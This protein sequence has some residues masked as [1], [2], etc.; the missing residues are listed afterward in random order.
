MFSD[1]MF[2]PNFVCWKIFGLWP[3]RGK[4]K[5]YKYYSFIYLTT[6][7]V[8]YNMLLTLNLV[9][10]P[11]AVETLIR[12]VIFYFNEIVVMC[13]VTMVLSMRK[14]IMAAFALLDSETF[15]CADNTSWKTSEKLFS[16]YRKLWKFYAL[17]SH[18][19]YVALVLPP[20]ANFVLN[21]QLSLPVCNY[22]FLSEETRR[23]YY[24]FWLTY[25][26]IGIY[27]H[28][29]YNVNIDTFMG[30]MILSGIEQ[31][32]SLHIALSNLNKS[33]EPLGCNLYI[34][35][36]ANASQMTKLNQCLQHYDML[37]E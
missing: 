18:I 1:R 23:K 12:E 35:S 27:G 15:K 8:V 11:I 32:K 24:S 16:A 28:M 22:Y 34:K 29:M 4:I 20:M 10:T 21:N 31:F 2:S 30:G 33:E 7:L 5:Y 25:Q 13:K 3:G 37:L 36:L 17:I 6:T 14:T 19:T 9:Y 26:S